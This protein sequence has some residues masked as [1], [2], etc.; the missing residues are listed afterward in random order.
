MI[1]RLFEK[2]DDKTA[3]E[4]VNTIMS[5]QTLKQR[6]KYPWQLARLRILANILL[7]RP[8]LRSDV[9]EFLEDLVDEKRTGAFLRGIKA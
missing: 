2:F 7:E 3:K 8:K 6:I 4:F 1:R 9:R 5:N